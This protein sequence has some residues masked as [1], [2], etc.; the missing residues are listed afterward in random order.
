VDGI[1]EES[2]GCGKEDVAAGR[3]CMLA[4]VLY[5]TSAFEIFEELESWRAGEL[6]S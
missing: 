3:V 2:G 4:I 1:E 5:C 6:E